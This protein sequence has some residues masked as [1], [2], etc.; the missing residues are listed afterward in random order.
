MK[1][2]EKIPNRQR[3]KYLC[4]SWMGTCIIVHS[5]SSDNAER[6]QHPLPC[7]LTVFAEYKNPGTAVNDGHSLG[8]LSQ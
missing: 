8:R 3:Y 7:S 2:Q 5:N 6:R 4:D 1:V